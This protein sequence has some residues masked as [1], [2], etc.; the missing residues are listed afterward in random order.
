MEAIMADRDTS[1]RVLENNRRAE[2][3]KGFDDPQATK[4]KDSK[5]LIA[6]ACAALVVAAVAMGLMWTNN[7]RYDGTSPAP[8]AEQGAPKDQPTQRTR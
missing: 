8:I 6:M 7:T 3:E 5:P 2:A 4:P 1:P